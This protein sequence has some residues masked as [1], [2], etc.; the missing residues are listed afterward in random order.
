MTRLLGAGFSFE[1]SGRVIENSLRYRFGATVTSL[2]IHILSSVV[3]RGGFVC[4]DLSASCD[5]DAAGFIDLEYTGIN[6]NTAASAVAGVTAAH[7]FAI[8]SE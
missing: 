3:S 6:D 1:T 8:R 7:Y 2:D 5:P 4:V